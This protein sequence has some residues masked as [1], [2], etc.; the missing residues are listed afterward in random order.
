MEY[1]GTMKTEKKQLH[2][3]MYNCLEYCIFAYLVYC[4]S[5]LQNINFMKA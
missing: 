1:Y 5:L 2:T 4:L 3:T